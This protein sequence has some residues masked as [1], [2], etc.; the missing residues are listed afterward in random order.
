MIV[1]DRPKIVW[2]SGRHVIISWTRTG[3][4]GGFGFDE[5]IF[6][7]WS[8]VIYKNAPF[9]RTRE[10]DRAIRMAR[11]I[12]GRI[13]YSGGAPDLRNAVNGRIWV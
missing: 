12:E 13:D 8:L 11:R 6:E 7:V 10:L 5:S 4:A 1:N 3:E 2:D 9:C